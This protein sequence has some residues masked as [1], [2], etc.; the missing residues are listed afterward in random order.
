MKSFKCSL[1]E[2]MSDC[3]KVINK[4]TIRGAAESFAEHAFWNHD[5]WEESSS[6]WDVFVLDMET[7]K[8][9]KVPI[10][11]RSQPEFWSGNEQEL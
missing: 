7:K 11:V 10:E 3:T 4:F 6:H 8:K 2:D 9:Y 5:M 1:Y